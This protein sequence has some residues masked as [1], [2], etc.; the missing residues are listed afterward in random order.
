MQFAPP[1]PSTFWNLSHFKNK[2][3]DF[4]WSIGSHQGAASSPISIYDALSYAMNFE[5]HTV[6]MR[7]VGGLIK[8]GFAA[9]LP[10]WPSSTRVQVAIAQVCVAGE[11]LGSSIILLLSFRSP[12]PFRS[13]SGVSG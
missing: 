3:S 11:R 8:S 6:T 13:G 5:D 7:Y 10:A 4:I 9:R 1:S 2:C 12:S